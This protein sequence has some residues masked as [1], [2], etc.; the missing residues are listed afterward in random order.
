MTSHAETVERYATVETSE[1]QRQTK[2]HP[3][4]LPWAIH[5]APIYRGKNVKTT[6]DDTI[7]LKPQKNKAL[8]KPCST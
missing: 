2:S 5:P 4:A 6:Y 7:F 8:E 1:T 3:R